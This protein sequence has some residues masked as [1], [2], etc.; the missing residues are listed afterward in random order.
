MFYMVLLEQGSGLTDPVHSPEFPEYLSELDDTTGL[1]ELRE[2][3]HI[4]IHIFT[5]V[6]FKDG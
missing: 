6:S 5:S 4:Q 1:S 3:L 2:N